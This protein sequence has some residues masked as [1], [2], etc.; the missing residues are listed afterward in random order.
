MKKTNPDWQAIDKLLQ[1]LAEMQQG[2]L[3]RC[4]RQIMP[5]ITADDLLQPNDFVEL[6]NHPVFRYEEGLLSGIQT[7]Q[8]ALRA[9]QRDIAPN[10]T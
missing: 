2:K 5:H 6:E 8:T 3:L 10:E 7:V 4:G 1:E 9:L